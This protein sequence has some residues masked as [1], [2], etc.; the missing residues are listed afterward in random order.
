MRN[1]EHHAEGLVASSETSSTGKSTIKK[2]KKENIRTDSCRQDKE[3]KNREKTEYNIRRCS[4][5][6]NTNVN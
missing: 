5:D 6:L 3:T 4:E 1:V 2:R